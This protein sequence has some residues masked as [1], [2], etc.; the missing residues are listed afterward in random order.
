MLADWRVWYAR[1]PAA[2]AGKVGPDDYPLHLFATVVT[3]V[4]LVGLCGAGAASLLGRVACPVWV[5]CLMLWLFNSGYAFVAFHF[6]G[7]QYVLLGLGVAALLSNGR[8]PYK[9]S[10]PNLGP[11]YAA[12]RAGRPVR[13]FGPPAARPPVPLLAADDLLAR[14]CESWQRDHGDRHPA[15]A[16]GRRRRRRGHPVGGVDGGG[17][18]GAGAGGRAA[19]SAGTSG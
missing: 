8:H 7:M 17:A 11:E 16:G 5:V 13:L 10:L 6:G 12:A 4:P 1:M 2:V 19:A 3:V 14:F 15:A 18:G 9:L